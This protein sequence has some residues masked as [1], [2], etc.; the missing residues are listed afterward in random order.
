[1]DL[2]AKAEYGHPLDA[3]ALNW[4]GWDAAL[5]VLPFRGKRLTLIKNF[6]PVTGLIGRRYEI[7]LPA[8]GRPRRLTAADLDGDGVEEVLVGTATNQLLR[9]SNPGA[10]E[11]SSELLWE[12]EYKPLFEGYARELAIEDMDADGDLDVLIAHEREPVLIHVLLND[13]TGRLRSV[14]R[15]PF[16]TRDGFGIQRL[17]AGA[18]QDDGFRYLLAQ[19]TSGAAL[20]RF[21]AGL[22]EEVSRLSLPSIPSAHGFVKALDDLDEDGSLDMVFLGGGDLKILFGPLWSELAGWAD[23]DI[24]KLNLLES[25]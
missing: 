19:S 4:P 6:D 25:E 20:Y 9:V 8:G 24:K 3:V 1:M 2:I 12:S 11:P 15:L 10:S 18:D 17:L 21:P 23:H 7:P 14:S 5:A 13:G 22:E 16:P